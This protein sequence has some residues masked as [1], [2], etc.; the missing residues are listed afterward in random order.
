MSVPGGAPAAEGDDAQEYNGEDGDEED[1]EEEDDDYDGEVDDEEDF[2]DGDDDEEEDEEDG[3]DAEA[4]AQRKKDLQS[5]IDVRPLDSCSHSEDVL[6]L[7]DRRMTRRRMTMTRGTV[8]VM[9][10]R[11]TRTTRMRRRKQRRPPAA[12]VKPRVPN[13][14]APSRRRPSRHENKNG[15]YGYRKTRQT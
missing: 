4:A 6:I 3:D 14:P 10:R 8:P 1:D 7:C 2:E 13:A 5:L 9:Q 11:R 12:S 15:L